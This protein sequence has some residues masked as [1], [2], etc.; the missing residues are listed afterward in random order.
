MYHVLHKTDTLETGWCLSTMTELIGG[1]TP[2]TPRSPGRDPPEE[3]GRGVLTPP[4]VAELGRWLSILLVTLAGISFPFWELV[5]LEAA[6]KWEEI[7]HYRTLIW[8][9]RKRLFFTIL[10]QECIQDYKIWR[11]V[12][13]KSSRFAD[14]QKFKNKY[15]CTHHVCLGLGH[16]RKCGWPWSLTCN[17]LGGMGLMLRSWGKHCLLGDGFWGA[18]VFVRQTALQIVREVSRGPVFCRCEIKIFFWKMMLT[19][20]SV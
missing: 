6:C 12:L 5:T 3:A 9:Q 20:F 2:L 4:T 16:T 10:G 18:E 13:N 14:F 15:L 11:K 19:I 1:A 17:D 8:T 7:I